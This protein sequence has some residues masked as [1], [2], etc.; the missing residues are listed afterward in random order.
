M[1]LQAIEK[2]GMHSMALIAIVAS[3][4][5]ICVA[6]VVILLASVIV[7]MARLFGI[8]IPPEEGAWL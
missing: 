6:L 7:C 3:M 8:D 2:A 1:I 5:M 4:V